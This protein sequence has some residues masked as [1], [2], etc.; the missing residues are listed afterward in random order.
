MGGVECCF[1]LNAILTRYGGATCDLS[2]PGGLRATSPHSR[3]RDSGLWCDLQL[4]HRVPLPHKYWADS[5]LQSG[6][7]WGGERGLRLCRE[8]RSPRALSCSLS[9]GSRHHGGAGR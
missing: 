5:C 4:C 7:L 3:S 6:L 1:C 2:T 8:D 9:D